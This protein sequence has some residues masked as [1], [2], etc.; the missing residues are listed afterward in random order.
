MNDASD[1][2]TGD[3]W[4]DISTPEDV[5]RAIEK[6]ERLAAAPSEVAAR[7]RCLDLLS[8]R[9]GEVIVDVGAGAGSVAIDIAR[10]IAPGG[11]VFAVDPSGGLLAR[12]RERAAEVEVGHLL[13]CR[14]ADGKA[15]PFGPAAFD[16]AFCHWVL[17]HVDQ[18]GKVIAE[19]RRVTRRG[20]RI[21][22]VEMD[23]ETVTVHPAQSAV[24][25]RILHHSSDRHRDAWS[26]RKLAGWFGAAGLV[27][28]TIE[29]IV[30]VDRGGANRAWLEYLRERAAIAR[31][32]GVVSPE[33]AASWIAPLEAA[34]IGGT[35]FFSVTQFAVVGRVPG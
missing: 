13:D 21:M 27:D 4:S 17:L 11:R 28:L 10:R 15:L 25:R 23:W 2:D 7:R 16:A 32:A 19:M 12:A 31:D 24:T 8:P 26:G 14:V 9:P 20:G 5:V 34:H 29:P 18:P 30:N 1:H 33:E 3:R 6:L 22:G 35:F